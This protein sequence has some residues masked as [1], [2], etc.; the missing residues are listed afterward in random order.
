MTS[1]F[2]SALDKAKGSLATTLSSIAENLETSQEKSR[3]DRDDKRKSKLKNSI[4]VI[5]P[6]DANATI[7]AERLKSVPLGVISSS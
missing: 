2:G 5:G 7:V 3:T 4:Q 6:C 1:I